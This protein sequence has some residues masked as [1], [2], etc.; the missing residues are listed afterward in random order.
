[1]TTRT[2][3]DYGKLVG[4]HKAVILGESHHHTPDYQEEVAQSLKKLR[5]L[6]FTHF[7]LEMLPSDVNVDNDKARVEQLKSHFEAGHAK[8]YQEAKR[9]GFTVV[10]LDMPYSK[11]Q[12]YPDPAGG[13]CYIDRNHWMVKTAM[14][15][16]GARHK[17]V[18][19][20]HHGHA[21]GKGSLQ[22]PDKEGV[23]SLLKAKGISTVYIR[24]SGGRAKSFCTTA[25]STPV[26]NLAQRDN[27]HHTR[28]ATAG[29]IG[30]DHVIHLPQS[31]TVR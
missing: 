5:S 9:T 23:R 25:I 18:L 20:M 22:T 6:G 16:L 13:R 21:F 11:Q 1:M 7:G 8:V 24:I 4:G 10:P 31:C 2:E 30:I 12:T 29:G 28:F 3:V 15:T 27:V 17:M 26:V 14:K 19:F